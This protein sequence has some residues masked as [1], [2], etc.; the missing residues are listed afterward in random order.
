ML[1]FT[2]LRPW[3]APRTDWAGVRT[4]SAMTMETSEDAN[5]LKKAAGELALLYGLPQRTACRFFISSVRCL[6]RRTR[7]CSFGSRS[8]ML[9]CID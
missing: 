5:S 8:V 6:S 2:T 9:A 7:P 4:P 1:G 3:T